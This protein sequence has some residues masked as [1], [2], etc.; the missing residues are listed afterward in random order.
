[1]AMTAV[2]VRQA[3]IE[4]GGKFKQ[5]VMANL[6]GG[7]AQPQANVT[8]ADLEY[9]M[10]ELAVAGSGEEPDEDEPRLD[11]GPVGPDEPSSGGHEHQA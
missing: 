8:L 5:W 4:D 7:E 9:D 2:A 10:P 6:D 1:M 11:G 3:G